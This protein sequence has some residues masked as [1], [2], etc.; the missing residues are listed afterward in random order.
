MD[1]RELQY[2]VTIADCHSFTQASK[3]LFIAQP[4]LSYA[5]SQIEKEVGVKLFDRSQQPL[6]L[7]DAGRM[8]VKTA[9]SILQQRTDLKNRIADLK[10]GQGAQISMGIPAE[11][12]GYM[13]PPIINQF[14][15]KYPKSEFMIRE[16][17]TVELM[18]LLAN[19]KVTFVVCPRD[20]EEIPSQMEA[21]LIYHEVVLLIA[22]PD[23]FSEDMFLDKDKR[24]VDLTKI[25]HLPFIGIKKRHSIHGKVNKLFQEYGVVPHL[26]LEVESSMTAVQLAACGLGYTIVPGRAK[27]ILGKDYAPYCYNYTDHPIQWDINAIYKRGTYLNKA[28]RYFIDLLKEKFRVLG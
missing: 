23:A 19:N 27:K 2:I 6:Q 18:E 24:M 28:E 17:G 12:A 21:E 8:Y 11:R 5:V 15:Q 14:R 13:L 10:Q 20:K 9:R 22:A 26:L 4:S 25:A 16:A 7:T 1:F 3:Q